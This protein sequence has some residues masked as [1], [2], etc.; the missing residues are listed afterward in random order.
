MAKTPKSSQNDTETSK[1]LTQEITL[2]SPITVEGAS[3]SRLTIRRP[4][5]RDMLASDKPS[6]SDAEKEINLFA[7]LCEVTPESLHEL[8]MADY[9]K[10]QQAYQ[11]FL[12]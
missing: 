5:V 1:P 4:K 10:L 3:I 9:G 7:N 6:K 2:I 11:D 12:S 8:D